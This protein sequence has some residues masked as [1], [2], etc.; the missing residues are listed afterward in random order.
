MLCGIFG[1]SP[2]SSRQNAIGLYY[3]C[4]LQGNQT[5]GSTMVLKNDA[6]GNRI[7]ANVLKFAGGLIAAGLMG[8][9]SK[10]A[11]PPVPPPAAV[12]VSH[13]LQKEVVEWDIYTG[14]LE[15]PQ[16][17][18]VAARVSGLIMEM[19]FAEGSMIKT[20]DLLAV[21]DDRPFKADLDSKK[22]DQEKA[23]V[24]ASIAVVTY[25]RL[26]GL[27]RKRSGTAGRG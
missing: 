2:A 23:E 17:A 4:L 3:G 11:A 10:P 19:P 6:R 13:P 20:G 16:S 12:S 26:Q 27:R 15:A 8:C 21:I 25:K 14:H 18:N 7:H 24:Q 9:D 1:K 5:K 22:A